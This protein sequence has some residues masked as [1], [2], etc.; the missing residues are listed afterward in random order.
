MATTFDDGMS[1]GRLRRYATQV[2]GGLEARHGLT[3]EAPTWR[4]MRARIVAERAEREAKDD[5]VTICAAKVRVD[6][7]DWD[8]SVGDLSG[9]SFL[10]AGKKAD[11]EPYS[12]LFGKVTAAQAK[13]LGRVKAAEVGQRLVKDGRRLGVPELEASLAALE[14]ATSALQAAG[15]ASDEAED[16]LFEPRRAKAKCVRDLNQLIAV[17]EARILTAF[18]G[19]SDLVSAILR[20]WWQRTRARS[21][22]NAAQPAGSGDPDNAPVDDGEDE[23]D[24][25]A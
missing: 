16:A 5:T 1:Y 3:A 12:V 7:A 18:P 24:G 13:Q 15:G 9:L 20:P 21:K 17:T 8:Q 22:T 11:A 4:D 25:E 23:G 19:R 2:I 6:D 14:A 10:L